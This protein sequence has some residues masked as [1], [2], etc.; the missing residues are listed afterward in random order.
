[1]ANCPPSTSGRQLAEHGHQ[2]A[3]LLSGSGRLAAAGQ[4]L[5]PARQ[6]RRSSK[7]GV[8]QAALTMAEEMV[9][10]TKSAERR[11]IQQMLNRSALGLVQIMLIVAFS[12]F[13]QTL[14]SRQPTASPN[15]PSP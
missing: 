4:R 12:G 9:S 5:I 14:V 2:H 1:M 13:Q 3:H 7:A 8:V 6:Q 11:Q 10:E 15:E